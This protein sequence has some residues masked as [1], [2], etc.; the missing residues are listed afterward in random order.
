ML[1]GMKTAAQNQPKL[2]FAKEITKNTLV[3]GFS[4]FSK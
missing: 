1:A 3:S 2:I 4:E